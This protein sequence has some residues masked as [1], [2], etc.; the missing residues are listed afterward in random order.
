MKGM[1]FIKMY[2]YTQNP[3]KEMSYTTVKNTQTQTDLKL[4]PTWPENILK[5]VPLPRT[6]FSS[7]QFSPE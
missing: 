6:G 2:G 1:S 5:N 3:K 7:I 4:T